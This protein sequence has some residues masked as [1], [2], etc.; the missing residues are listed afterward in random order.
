MSLRKRQRKSTQE[1]IS[2]QE[3]AIWLGRAMSTSEVALR[4]ATQFL[5]LIDLQQ[6]TLQAMH[7]V[8]TQNAGI[9]IPEELDQVLKDGTSSEVLKQL[10]EI[11]QELKPILRA[12]DDACK[13]LEK[14]I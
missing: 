5:D 4:M 3:T 6:R 8:I 12:I 2:R 1:A 10:E 9:S 14:M 13:K 11:R 7:E